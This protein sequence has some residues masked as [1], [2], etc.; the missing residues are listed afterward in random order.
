MSGTGD[1][2]QG[3]HSSDRRTFN[4]EVL[5]FVVL[6]K[7]CW[8]GFGWLG[9]L[10][11]RHGELCV[12]FSGGDNGAGEMRQEEGCDLCTVLCSRRMRYDS[13]EGSL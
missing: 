5:E 1:V 11:G 7:S 2:G 10:F 9:G 3:R 8:N 12:K 13:R 4:R 6:F